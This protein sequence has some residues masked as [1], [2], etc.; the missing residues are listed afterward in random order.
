MLALLPVLYR[1]LCERKTWAGHFET[2]NNPLTDALTSAHTSALVAFQ[3]TPLTSHTL[4]H[5]AAD[6]PN[7]PFVVVF[8]GWC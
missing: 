6:C 3:P 2:T 5:H 1:L 8:V 7:Q 4:D